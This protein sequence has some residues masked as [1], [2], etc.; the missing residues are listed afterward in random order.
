M[1]YLTISAKCGQYLSA[2]FCNFTFVSR[3]SGEGENAMY[4][5]LNYELARM[6]QKDKLDKAEKVREALRST[7]HQLDGVA[8]GVG[9]GS[10]P[11]TPGLGRGLSQ[12]GNTRHLETVVD[13]V[14]VVDREV[15]HDPKRVA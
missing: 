15:E 11:T 14:E 7:R 10:Y 9:V 5:T 2:L 3:L 12:T 4:F 8:I 1:H 13:L 6:I